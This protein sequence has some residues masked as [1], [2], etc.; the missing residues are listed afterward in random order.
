MKT[1]KHVH[2]EV[3]AATPERLFALLCTPSAIR[4]WW[5]A[6]RAVVL[7]QPG[8]VWAAAWGAVEDDPDYITAAT[9]KVF[10]PPWRMVLTDYRYQAKAG[11]LPFEAE[12]VTEF[13]VEPHG[14]G[15]VLRV[16]QD[17][18]PAGREADA[19]YAGCE[20]GWRETFAGIRA[21]LVETHAAF[22]K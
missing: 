20:R 16:S 6:D 19:F 4:R 10:S 11:A 21:F 15:A 7:A 14:Q 12:F 17:G 22:A 5:G 13:T 2:Q 18:F 3:F 1:R 9:I 8:G